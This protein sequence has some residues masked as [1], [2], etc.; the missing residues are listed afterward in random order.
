MTAAVSAAEQEAPPHSEEPGRSIADRLKPPFRGDLLAALLLAIAS[1]LL[2]AAVA[3]LARARIISFDSDIPFL[4]ELS[5]VSLILTI[6]AFLWSWGKDWRWLHAE[7]HDIEGLLSNEQAQ[8]DPKLLLHRGHT[9]HG[10]RRIETLLDDRVT[11]VLTMSPEA[12][13]L[14]ESELR[15]VA[16]WR[17]ATLGSLARYTSGLLLLMTVFGTFLGV[18]SSLGPLGQALL[19]S[20]SGG[21]TA[22]ANALAVPLAR[23][24]TAF[25]ANLMALIGAITLGL[26]AWALSV[27][28]QNMLARLEQASSLYLYP[29]VKQRGPLDHLAGAAQQIRAAAAGMTSAAGT[30]TQV[31]ATIS[32]ELGGVRDSLADQLGSLGDSVGDFSASIDDSLKQ[33]REALKQLVV[34]QASDAAEESRRTVDRVERQITDTTIAVQQATALYGSLVTRLEADAVTVSESLR[35]LGDTLA[36]VRSQREAFAHYAD[37]ATRTLETRLARLEESGRRQLEVA[38]ATHQRYQQIHSS[39]TDLTTHIVVLSATLAESE[40]RNREAQSEVA[41]TT[42][43]RV[44][45]L[46]RPMMSTVDERLGTLATTLGILP[47]QISR[48]VRESAPPLPMTLPSGPTPPDLRPALERLSGV[49][50][51]FDKRMSQPLWRRLMGRKP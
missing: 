12:A 41:E 23:V 45:E 11:R 21:S 42:A 30:L 31:N 5:V 19:Q 3:T 20:A 7:E 34:R 47:E 33:T 44:A 48:A 2:V 16:L 1:G 32:Q 17:S 15:A 25:G 18:K 22:T 46:L 35:T 27:G 49:L 50:D 24:A 37:S 40:R 9:T 14:R 6:A 26:G 39:L 4:S 13:P 43:R 38:E 29:F 51:R 10:T 8:R 28:R 36:E